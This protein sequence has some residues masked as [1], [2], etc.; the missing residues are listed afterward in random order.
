MSRGS[1]V[2]GAE[3]SS[4]NTSARPA[5]STDAKMSFGTP[6]HGLPACTD[7]EL[8]ERQRTARPHHDSMISCGVSWPA[9]VRIRENQACERLDGRGKGLPQVEPETRPGSSLRTV[10]QA[11]FQK[12]DKSSYICFLVSLT[13]GHLVLPH[14]VREVRKTRDSDSH[15]TERKIL[16]KLHRSPETR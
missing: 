10:S 2:T 14:L 3:E 5:R 4:W 7:A 11:L 12:V 6:V 9:T 16:P 13:S 15:H 1:H 8:S